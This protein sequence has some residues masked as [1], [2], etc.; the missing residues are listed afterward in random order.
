MNKTVEEARSLVY[1][2][3]AK[4]REING[5]EKVLCPPFPPYLPYMHN[6]RAA[7]WVSVP[8]ICIGKKKALL[9]AKSH[10]SW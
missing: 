2:M 5:V 10:R 4:L 9:Q 8:K 3:S 6:W 1:S 7:T